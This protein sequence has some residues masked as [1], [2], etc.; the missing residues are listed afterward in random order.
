M[1]SWWVPDEARAAC[2]CG[3][4]FTFLERRHHCRECGEVFCGSCAP[5]TAPSQERKCLPCAEPEAQKAE[6]L[7]A[8]WRRK[9]DDD[10]LSNYES[11]WA[12][13]V[14]R[15][16]FQR[17]TRE[18]TD[19]VYAE[20][21]ER[22]AA[23]VAAMPAAET[24]AKLRTLLRRRKDVGLREMTD[25][26]QLWHDAILKFDA[27]A[28]KRI[29]SQESARSVEAVADRLAEL[30]ASGQA[31]AAAGGAGGRAARAT[32]PSAAAGS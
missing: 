20:R 12:G 26:E 10:P 3:L 16:L 17:I 6:R 7:R 24:E 13:A 8:L 21:V 11:A 15:S 1:G 4:S 18:V 5:V 31:R 22:V 28:F 14:D 9:M 27:S 23:Q 30:R 2:A 29:E 19:D 32:S 25:D